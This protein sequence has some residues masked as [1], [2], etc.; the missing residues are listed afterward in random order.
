MIR[1]A[2][3]YLVSA[4]SGATLIAVA[5]VAFVV[6]V[7]AQVFEA[8]PVATL[9]GSDGGGRV[10][11]ARAVLGSAGAARAGSGGIAASSGAKA[12]TEAGGG[13]GDNAGAGHG[14][15]GGGSQPEE[16]SFAGSPESAGGGGGGSGGSGGS[17]GGNSTAS[18]PSG[19]GSGG[20]PSGSSSSSPSGGGSS[21]GGGSSSGGSTTSTTSGELTETVNSTVSG[22]DEKVLGGALQESGVTEATEGVVNG[23]AG[24][25]SIV[26]NVVDETVE[27]VGGLL[28][29]H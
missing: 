19:G 21:A 20:S 15:A 5:I 1:Q 3:T 13:S 4:M 12:G 2:R 29:K 8:W 10:S 26:G 24:P 14:N 22:V 6:L 23:A 17:G 18:Q 11:R 7:S 27:A 16:A 9:G 25:E 28:G